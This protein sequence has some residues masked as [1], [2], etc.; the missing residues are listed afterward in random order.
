[1]YK[2]SIFI[3]F[4][5]LLYLFLNGVDGF[6]V[7]VPTY[8]IVYIDEEMGVPPPSPQ[9]T[10]DSLD[11][12]TNGQQ[13]TIQEYIDSLDDPE[14]FQ[15]IEVGGGLVPDEPPAIG[16][17][18]ISPPRVLKDPLEI[19][20]GHR[21]YVFIKKDGH[22]QITEFDEQGWI[23]GYITISG[24][25]YPIAIPD[26]LIIPDEF[27]YEGSIKS[28]TES[29]G[30]PGGPVRPSII[31]IINGTLSHLDDGTFRDYNKFRNFI[32]KVI[33]YLRGDSELNVNIRLLC[34]WSPTNVPGS[35]AGSPAILNGWVKPD[36][37]LWDR[38]GKLRQQYL[39][40]ES[41]GEKCASR[42]GKCRRYVPKKR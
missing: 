12:A 9:F 23:D 32:C 25:R 29:L 19:P 36:S 1:M 34:E 6:S 22:Y 16:T 11:T 2:Y 40:K 26:R 39:V 37:P 24:K 41:Q 13:Q 38:L 42:T 4:G 33:E 15:G 7:G 8:E 35:N 5:I 27:M 3:I 30:I 28:A 20:E 21:L 18:A 10:G 17:P 31:E 14:L